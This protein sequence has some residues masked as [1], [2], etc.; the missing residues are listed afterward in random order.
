MSNKE[1]QGP[2][3]RK[4][5]VMLT[6]FDGVTDDELHESLCKILCEGWSVNDAVEQGFNLDIDSTYDVQVIG[7]ITDVAQD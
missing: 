6:I 3:E 7:S 4:V 5:I 2:K 1:T